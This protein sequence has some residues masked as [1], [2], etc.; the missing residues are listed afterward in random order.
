QD[1]FSIQKLLSAALVFI[2]VYLVTQSKS[3]EDIEKERAVKTAKA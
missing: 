3:R 2:G 1:S